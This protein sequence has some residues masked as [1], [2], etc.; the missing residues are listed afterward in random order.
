[1]AVLVYVYVANFINFYPESM[2]REASARI[3]LK[4]KV[5]VWDFVVVEDLCCCKDIDMD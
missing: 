2:N 5:W 4:G 1:M 3:E